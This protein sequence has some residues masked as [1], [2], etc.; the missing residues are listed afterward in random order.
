MTGR[1]GNVQFHATAVTFYLFAVLKQ[2]V[3]MVRICGIMHMKQNHSTII[4]LL[5]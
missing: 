1:K 5:I 2:G 4:T 3:W